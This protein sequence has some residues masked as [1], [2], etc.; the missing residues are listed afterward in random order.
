MSLTPLGDLLDAQTAPGV[1]VQSVE[2]LL[3]SC[4]PGLFDAMH[5][6]N[7]ATGAVCNRVDPFLKLYEFRIH[8]FRV[9]PPVAGGTGTGDEKSIVA[10][11]TTQIATR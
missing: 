10:T 1:D 4:G 7:D 5:A 9:T 2:D 8:I 11:L 3:G 6:T